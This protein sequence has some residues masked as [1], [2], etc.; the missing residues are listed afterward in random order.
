VLSR[1]K[2]ILLLAGRLMLKRIAEHV[3]RGD[4]FAFET[5]LSDRSFARS[6]EAWQRE[7]YYITLWFL[8]LPNVEMAINRVAQRVRHGGHT[9]PIDVVR[10]RF[11]AG[12]ENFEAIYRQAVDAWLLYDNSGR[13]PALLDW[14]EKP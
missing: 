3:E 12:R 11:I 1:P 6:I 5:T 7:G 13:V 8:A 9:V 14:G 4:S 2:E 10:R